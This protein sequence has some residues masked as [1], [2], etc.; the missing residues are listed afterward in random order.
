MKVGRY[1]LDLAAQRLNLPENLQMQVCSNQFGL[2]RS[3]NWSACLPSSDLNTNR[4]KTCLS[5]IRQSHTFLK[6]WGGCRNSNASPVPAADIRLLFEYYVSPPAPNILATW[7]IHGDGARRR[8][9]PG[10]TA[11]FGQVLLPRLPS[12]PQGG[13]YQE[14]TNSPIT[15]C[16]LSVGHL[17]YLVPGVCG[18]GKELLLLLLLFVVFRCPVSCPVT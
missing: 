12:V 7:L 18:R 5:P 4:S 2:L 15:Q 14:H 10:R 11:P 3:S 17:V 6:G 1:S 13:G 8:P 16:H 9:D